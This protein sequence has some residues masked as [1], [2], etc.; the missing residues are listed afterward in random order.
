MTSAKLL[1]P[2]LTLLAL[3]TTTAQSQPL[4]GS[5]LRITL[6]T[7]WQFRE[8]GKDAW[9]PAIVPGCVHTDLLNNKLIDDPFYRDNEQK[10]QWIGKTDWEY[11]TIFDVAPETF[12]REKIELVFEGLDT[13]AEVFVNNETLLAADNMFRTW[14]VDCKR[15]LKAGANT[16]R[17]VFRSPINEI[18][19]LMAKLSYQL[20]A[21]NDQGEKTS[22]HTR[23]APYQYG[24]DWGPRFV[25]SGIWRPVY[26]ESWEKARVEDVHILPKQATAAAANLTAEVEVVANTEATATIVVDNLTDKSIAA[27]R[28][29]N[30]APGSNRVLL[31]FVIARPALWWPNG[32]GA[33][34][35]YSF[36]AR[37]LIN[38]KLIDAK[39]TRTGLRSLELRQQLDDSGKSFTFVINGEPVFAKGANWIP[40]DSFPTRITRAKYRQLLESARDSNMNMLRV[41]GGGIYERDDFYELAD[42]MGILL[43][44]DFMFGCSMYPGDQAYLDNVRQEASDNV[45]RLRNHPSIVIWVGNNEIETAWKHWGWKDQ[46]PAALWDDYLKIFHGILP[47]VCRSLDP[48]RPYWPSSPSSNLEDDPDSQKMGDVHYWQVWHAALPFSEY[49]KQ[50]PRFM[51]EYGFQSFPPIETVNTYTTLADHDIQSPVMMAHQRHPRGNQLI[52]E[53]MLREYPEPKDFESFLYVSQVLQAEGIKIGAEHLRRIMPHNMGSLF[54]QLNDCWPVASWSSIDYTGRWKALQYYARRFYNDILVSP[55]FENDKLDIFVVSDRL[56]PAAAQLNLS[57][58]DFDGNQLWAQRQDIEIQPLTSRSYTTVAGASLLS[59]RDS[60]AVFLLSEVLVDG[61]LVSSN[62]K[63]F[64]PYKNLSLPPSHITTGVAAVRGGFKITL[65]AD[66][67]ARSVYL[68]A[69]EYGGA[70]SDNYFDLIPGRRVEVVFHPSEAVALKDFRSKLKVRTMADAF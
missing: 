49:E 4:Q 25:T 35:L 19:P 3:I 24:W 60:K 58:L 68:S 45:K 18:L 13:Y 2:S 28:E 34:P 64:E 20:P 39:T 32:L 43:W 53:Y 42:E 66:K 50:F 51:S 8:V 56:Q 65:A 14:R 67:F 22:P 63:F 31:D 47:E 15:Q 27:K 52:R 41:W 17:I 62:E 33:H 5:V 48:S 7:G 54:W 36:K 61:K 57:L 9:H 44:Q 59:R 30:L 40:A 23:K 55:Q 69:A 6:A 29:V 12:A 46:L 70:F 38:G 21:S 1:M 10:L 11:Q 26:L 16:L 37:L